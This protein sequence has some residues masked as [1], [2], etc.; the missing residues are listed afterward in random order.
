M[1][2]RA[3]RYPSGLFPEVRHAAYH[4]VVVAK[5]AVAM[6]LVKTLEHQADIIQHVRP[7]RM[8]RQFGLLPRSHGSR[9]LPPQVADALFQGLQLP[10]GFGVIP[11][12]AFKQGNLL[13]NLLQLKLGC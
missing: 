13:F 4:R 3:L 9:H 8:P 12:G 2:R 6:N 10:L 1:A 5:A 7:L 11:G